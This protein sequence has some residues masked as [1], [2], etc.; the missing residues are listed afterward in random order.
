[1]TKPEPLLFLNDARGIYLPRDFTC[2]VARDRVIGVSDEDWAILEAGPDHEHYW[3]VWN[4]IEQDAIVTDNKGVRYRLHQDG[5]LW[6]IPLGMEWDDEADGWRW[7][8][9]DA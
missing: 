4:E 8:E 2:N 3:D 5:D 1:M 6:L 9:E 7:P